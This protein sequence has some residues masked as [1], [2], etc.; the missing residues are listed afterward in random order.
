VRYEAIFT[1]L[2]FIYEKRENNEMV[3]IV[4]KSGWKFHWQVLFSDV[5]EALSSSLLL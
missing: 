3:W 4:I 5:A 1:S 2:L